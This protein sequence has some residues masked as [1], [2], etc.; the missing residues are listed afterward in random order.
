MTETP[1]SATPGQTQSRPALE[2]PADRGQHGEPCQECGAPLAADQRY[3]LNCGR[4]RGGA[5]VD[6]RHYMA[7]AADAGEAEEQASPRSGPLPP[8][9][10]SPSQPAADGDEPQRDYAPLAA[11][12]GIAVL[13]LMLL[14]GVLIGRGGDSSTPAPAPIVV[15][16]SGE[17]AEASTAKEGGAG[18][19]KSPATVAPEP[20]GK[21]KGGS[22]AGSGSAK[23]EEP[24]EASDE[25]LESLH[26]QSGASYEEQSKKLPNEIATPGKPPPID[27]TTA[28]GGGEGGG[29]VIK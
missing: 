2:L 25:A 13:G 6:Y 8:Q 18:A 9:T 24:V 12:G 29:E 5:R 3:C 20:G 17:G 22:L 7:T 11:V 23:S 27:K 26:S 16:G 10:T 21:Q 28:P 4:R 1:I 14:V 19:G 15:H